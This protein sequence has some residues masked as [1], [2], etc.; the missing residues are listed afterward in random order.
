M[1]LVIPG[2]SLSEQG[3]HSGKSLR[4]LLTLHPQSRAERT[5]EITRGGAQSV[6]SVLQSPWSPCSL[7]DI[8]HNQSRASHLY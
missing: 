7:N 3:D 4:E 5:S 2:F 6:V 8:V 1:W